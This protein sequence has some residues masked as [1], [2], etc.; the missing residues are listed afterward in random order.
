LSKLQRFNFEQRGR[1]LGKLEE[2]LDDAN[3]GGQLKPDLLLKVTD[4]N[5]LLTERLQPVLL[6]AKGTTAEEFLEGINSFNQVRVE[7]LREACA[8]A[9]ALGENREQII[10]RVKDIYNQTGK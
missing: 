10:K 2:Q 6:Q 7:Q 1:V 9:L 8:Q 5:R 4:E 3:G